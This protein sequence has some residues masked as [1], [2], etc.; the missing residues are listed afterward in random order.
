MGGDGQVVRRQYTLAV[1]YKRV[2]RADG[3]H[4][5]ETHTVIVLAHVDQSLLARVTVD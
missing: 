2:L 3:Y 5:L 4:L 1:G